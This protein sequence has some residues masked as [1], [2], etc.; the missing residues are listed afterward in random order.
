MTAVHIHSES[1]GPLSAPVV[2]LLNSLGSTLAMW[3][4]QM[5]PL[6]SH[7]RVIRCD[8]RGH[9]LSP[10]PPGPYSIDDLVDDTVALLDR[11]ELDR[12]HVVGLSLG[13]M[14][15]LRLAAREPDRVDRLAVLCTSALLGPP[16]GWAER[17]RL[18]RAEGTVAVAST[19]VGRWLTPEHRSADPEFAAQLE[20]MIA[21]TP[22]EG[23]AASCAAIEHLDLRADL[24][25]ITAPTLAIAGAQDPVTPPPHLAAIVDAVPGSRLLVV[26]AAAHLAN[27]GQPAIVS[28]ALVEHLTGAL[29]TDSED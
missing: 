21:A 23:Y 22:A 18:V 5:S 9:G 3:D 20:A 8:L 7:F 25:S 16:E 2:L 12:A 24:G 13:G 26:D 6:R 28:A 11:W 14:A 19:V 1:S 17:A 4:L 15:A 10:V 27:V 29:P